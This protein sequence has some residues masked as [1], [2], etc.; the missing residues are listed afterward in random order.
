MLNKIDVVIEKNEIINLAVKLIWNATEKSVSSVIFNAETVTVL[1]QA[2][3]HS[4]IVNLDK[5][6]LVIIKGETYRKLKE[7]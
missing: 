5:T 4:I 7:K 6:D 1:S 3:S 2:H